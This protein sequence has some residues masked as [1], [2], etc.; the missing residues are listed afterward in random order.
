[1]PVSDRGWV[2]VK[3]S[4][5]SPNNGARY[6]PCVGIMLI[7]KKGL[8]WIGRRCD[9]G[10]R[11]KSRF[12]LLWQMPQGGIASGEEPVQAARRELFEETKISSCSFLAESGDWLSYDFPPGATGKR[13]RGKWIG[14]TQKWFAFSF[15]GDDREVVLDGG[16]GG[17]REF[18]AWRWEEARKLPELVVNFKRPIYRKVIEEFHHLLQWEDSQDAGVVTPSLTTSPQDLT[19][20]TIP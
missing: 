18:S 12:P 2:Y 9:L 7:N 13:W 11:K 5:I 16:A 8:V 17:R 6:R 20:T 1:M 15:D 3:D 4:Y 10:K 19:E 14:Q